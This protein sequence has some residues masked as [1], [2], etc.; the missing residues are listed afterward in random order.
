MAPVAKLVDVLIGDCRDV[1]IRPSSRVGDVWI[2]PSSRVGDVR[3]RPSSRVGDVWIRPSNQQLAVL[4]DE[5]MHHSA[6]CA[7]S[8]VVSAQIAEWYLRR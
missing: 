1:R 4:L 5:M 2:R 3:I 8:G 7:D 6:I